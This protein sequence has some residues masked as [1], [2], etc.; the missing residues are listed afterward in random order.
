MMVFTMIVPNYGADIQ[1][2]KRIMAP[3]TADY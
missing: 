1:K 2:V 3:S